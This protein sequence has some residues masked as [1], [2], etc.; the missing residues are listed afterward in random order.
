MSLFK[1]AVRGNNY[2][3][4]ALVGP[5]GSGKTY[6]ALALASEWGTP[7]LIDLE[8]GWEHFPFAFDRLVAKGL[9]EVLAGIEAAKQAGI[10]VLVIDCLS[11]I[12]FGPTGLMQLVD[13]QG[14][15]GWN[16]LDGELAKLYA[17]IHAYPGHALCTVRAEEIR[18]V[19]PAGE[20][21]QR[22]RLACGKV[23]F[24]ADVGSHF[25]VIL[26]LSQG[27]ADCK[28]GPPS[29]YNRLFP[30]PGPEL[31][32]ILFASGSQA[33]PPAPEVSSPLEAVP[34][35][36]IH[37]SEPPPAVASPPGNGGISTPPLEPSKPGG[38][39]DSEEEDPSVITIKR[40]RLK[41]HEVAGRGAARKDIRYAFTANNGEFNGA[42][43]LVELPLIRREY[44]WGQLEELALAA[45]KRGGHA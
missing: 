24:K 32:G 13:Q 16:A 29:C 8:G 2:Q 42:G 11:S 4:L 19:E 30:F 31:A 26:E 14:S 39:L 18:L 7:G 9:T 20:G 27:V 10:G 15:K 21:A 33:S 28:K 3:R 44:C 12:Y 6:S 1:A 17:A 36:P 23:A 22:I 38:S 5:S 37:P 45:E 41:G 25:G 43:E 34:E 35:I 40:L